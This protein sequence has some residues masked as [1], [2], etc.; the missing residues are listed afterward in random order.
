[1]CVNHLQSYHRNLNCVSD[2]HGD[3]SLLLKRKTA[4]LNRAWHVSC[5][6][7]GCGEDE[8]LGYD[9]RGWTDPAHPR[10]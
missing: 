3:G 2:T 1:M 9:E 4:K 7:M 5:D 8:V 6:P 10:S